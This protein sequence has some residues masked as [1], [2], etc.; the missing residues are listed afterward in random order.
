VSSK[1][2]NRGLMR[3]LGRVLGIED[4]AQAPSRLRTDELIPVISMDAGFSNYQ[5][6]Q[7][8]GSNIDLEGINN[9]VWVPI[10]NQNLSVAGVSPSNVISNNGESEVV[11]L[12]MRI[13]ITYANPALDN[14]SVMGLE[15]MRQAAGSIISAS[16]ESTF[17]RWVTGDGTRN[18]FDWC[19]P[20]Y[21]NQQFDDGDPSTFVDGGNIMSMPY[22][23]VP[24]G[25]IFAISCI[26]ISGA[27]VWPAG[28]TASL[29]AF[30]VSCPKG[31]RPPCM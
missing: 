22:I 5:Q 1:I 2:G 31:M 13:R 23:F 14:P 11:I 25:S 8:Y 26:K 27:G 9:F 15:F 30:A 29:T 20:W 4:V 21:Q 7:L 6:H 10:G 24:A 12:G 3:S 16:S 18:I 28:T 19:F 17:R